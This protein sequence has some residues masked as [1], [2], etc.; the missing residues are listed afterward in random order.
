MKQEELGIECDAA[1]SSGQKTMRGKRK[2]KNERGEGAVEGENKQKSVRKGDNNNQ[3][4]KKKEITNKHTTK[5]GEGCRI[6]WGRGTLL[7]KGD[8][9]VTSLQT[10][11]TVI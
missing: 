6:G 7:P 2:K 9:V 10:T 11:S 3:N 8:K 1:S 4:E 5:K